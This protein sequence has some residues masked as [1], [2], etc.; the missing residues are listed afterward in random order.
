MR[1]PALYQDPFAPV[2][3]SSPAVVITDE[4]RMYIRE[5]LEIACSDTQFADKAYRSIVRILTGGSV[6]TPTVASLSPSGAVI[7]SPSF[8][9]HV[10]G[11]GFSPLSKIVFAGN[12]E[13]TTFVSPTELTTGVNMDVWLGPDAVP[14]GVLSEDGVLSNTVPFTFTTAATQ[15][16]QGAGL[17]TPKPVTQPVHHTGQTTGV[18]K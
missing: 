18:K 14:V 8:D 17:I 6:V 9:V 11:D 15:S 13:P 5:V 1:A 7:G 3:L 12:E 16:V 4:Q 2:L 10:I